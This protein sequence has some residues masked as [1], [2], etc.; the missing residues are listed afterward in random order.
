[1]HNEAVMEPYVDFKYYKESF[2]GTQIPERDFPKHEMQAE[3]F[4]RRITFGRIKRLPE[5]PDEVKNAICS[6][7]EA[8]FQE[9]KKTP[10]IRSENKDGYSVVYGDSG[11]KSMNDEMYQTARNYLS[12]TGLLFRG[13]SRKYDYQC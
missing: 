7:A 12:D 4:L 5:I 6:M 8:S 10:G 11:T 1:M 9:G 2:H 3:A 13:R